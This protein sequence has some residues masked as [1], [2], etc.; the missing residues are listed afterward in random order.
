MLFR[1]KHK[2]R[3]RFYLFP[4]QGGRS[5]REKQRRIM[6]WTISLA[7]IFAATMAGVMWWLSHHP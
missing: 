4:G 7:L 6:R 2:P 5:Y 1:K 3:E